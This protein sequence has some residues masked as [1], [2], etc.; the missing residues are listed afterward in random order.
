MRA[1][2]SLQRTSLAELPDE[3]LLNL[4]SF[5]DQNGLVA[6]GATCRELFNLVVHECFRL[7][8]RWQRRRFLDEAVSFF[9]AVLRLDPRHAGALDERAIAL[10]NMSNRPGAVADLLRSAALAKQESERLTYESVAMEMRGELQAALQTARKAIAIDPTNGRAHFEMA[11]VLQELPFRP[12]HK[13]AVAA[14]T[15]AYEN[16]CKCL[17]ENYLLFLL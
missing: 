14:Y 7:G 10:F 1:L 6:C 2:S 9:S 13:G 16:G 15:K 8:V 5:L 3:V 17:I 4:M 12:D 11:Y